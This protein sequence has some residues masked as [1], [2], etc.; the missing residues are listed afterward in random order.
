MP[1]TRQALAYLVEQFPVPSNSTGILAEAAA[2]PSWST[3]GP[4]RF[5]SLLDLP[6]TNVGLPE[7][8]RL[9]PYEVPRDDFRFEPISAL[10]ESFRHS[11]WALHRRKVF[12][13]MLS[14]NLSP[15]RLDRFANCGSH[16]VI[17]YHPKEDAYAVQANYCRDRFCLRCGQMRS[18]VIARN[19]GDRLDGINCRLC[20]LTLRHS[21]TPLKDQISR[22]LS[23]FRALRHRLFWRTAVS[24]GVAFLELKLGKDG[25]WH[26]HL[27]CMV[28]T[29]WLDQKA[30][31]FEWHAVTGDS[32]I[33]DVRPIHSVEEVTRYVSKY[34]SKPM[35][36][37]LFS[38]KERLAEAISALHGR[39]LCT[40]FGNWRGWKIEEKQPRDEDAIFMGT[41]ESLIQD[42]NRGDPEA[43]KIL[44][45]LTHQKRSREKG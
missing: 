38:S 21:A 31:S 18:A 2:C 40:T 3:D 44:S 19:L 7:A 25:L 16:A 4:P 42:A 39:R 1:I 27:H 45:Q 35:D 29:D 34:A 37:S 26:P 24:G 15:N 43:K 13:A 17:M 28:V 22:L 20:T 6:E 5:L 32:S 36:P 23:S 41:L 30:L 12:D 10:E 9:P 8:E 11:G 33:V 14:L